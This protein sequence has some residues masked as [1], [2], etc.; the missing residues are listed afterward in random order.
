[1]GRKQYTATAEVSTSVVDDYTRTKWMHFTKVKSSKS[2][3]DGLRVF[4]ADIAKPENLTIG[5]V[6]TDEGEEFEG[7]FQHLP[8]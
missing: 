5:V 7:D 1:M 8:T 6:R 3:A 4:I 2:I